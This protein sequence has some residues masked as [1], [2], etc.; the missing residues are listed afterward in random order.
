MAVDQYSKA[1]LMDSTWNIGGHMF[2]EGLEANPL[3]NTSSQSRPTWY[4]LSTDDAICGF[5]S[6]ATASDTITTSSSLPGNTRTASIP[7]TKTPAATPI[8]TCLLYTSDA[9]DEEDSVDLGGRR[10]IKK[11]NINIKNS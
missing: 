8:H 11:K 9:A 5:S 10:I 1:S 2:G 7:P 4:Q 3:T 6:T